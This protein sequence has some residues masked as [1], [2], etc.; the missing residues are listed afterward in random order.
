MG[1]GDLDLA[2]PGDIL[3]DEDE[4]GRYNKSRFT[5]EIGLR[6]V[7]FSVP[8]FSEGL[9]TYGHQQQQQPSSAAAHCRSAGHPSLGLSKLATVDSRLSSTPRFVC[10]GFYP[11]CQLISRPADLVLQPNT[12]ERL[13]PA[14]PF[15]PDITRSTNPVKSNPAAIPTRPTVRLKSPSARKK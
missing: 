5:A 2:S 4:S 6:L 7:L 1:E 9:E 12:N 10:G 11:N 13:Q 8:F 14:I 15:H 3:K